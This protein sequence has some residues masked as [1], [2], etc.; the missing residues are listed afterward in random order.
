MEIT[1]T[2]EGVIYCDGITCDPLGLFLTNDE[3]GSR[4]LIK[5][6]AKFSEEYFDI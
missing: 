4:P 3:C 5:I 6:C 1:I 2:S